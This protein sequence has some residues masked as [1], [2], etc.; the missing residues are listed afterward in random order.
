[1]S[2]MCARH[3]QGVFLCVCLCEHVCM[4][5]GLSL[6]CVPPWV[7]TLV[8]AHGHMSLHA[9]IVGCAHVQGV[10]MA[11]GVCVPTSGLWSCVT[12]VPCCPCV[13]RCWGWAHVCAGSGAM[14]PCPGITAWTTWH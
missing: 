12:C 14:S 2:H 5:E 8:C 1:M 9:D 7:D 13:P 10:P 11:V 3:V 4:W 6:G